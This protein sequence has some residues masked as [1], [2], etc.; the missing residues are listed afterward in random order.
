MKP[1]GTQERRRGENVSDYQSVEKAFRVLE[2]LALHGQKGVTE[3]AASLSMDKGAV[4]RMLKT[5]SLLGYAEQ[6]QQRGRYGVGPSLLFLGRR[7]LDES[8]IIARARPVLAHLSA[9]ARATTLLSMPVGRH[10]IILHKQPSPERIAVGCSIGDE[11]TPHASAMGKVLLAGMSRQER[12][13]FIR[14]PLARFTKA[15]ITDRRTFESLLD[16]VSRDGYAVE[17]EEEDLGVGC[18]ASPLRDGTGRWFAAISATGPL[19]GTPFS[20]DAE[21][22]EMVKRAAMTISLEFGYRGA[23]AAG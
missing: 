12:A 4:S 18:I 3:L 14:Y 6:T 22:I 8:D 19:S 1:E 9:Q 20:V 2:E 5:L 10:L 13:R 17:V 23:L 15:T 16:E 11:L 7:Y 21:H